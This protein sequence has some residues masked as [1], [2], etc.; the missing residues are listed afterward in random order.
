M[1]GLAA[2]LLIAV[3]AASPSPSAAPSP[4]PAEEHPILRPP[5]TEETPAVGSP[6]AALY[7]F[8]TE[9]RRSEFQSAAKYLDLSAIPPSDREGQGPKL[10]RHLKVVLDRNIWFD[11]SKVSNRAEGKTDDGLPPNAEL[12]GSISSAGALVDVVMVRGP[13]DTGELVWRFSPALVERIPALYTE[14][15][16]G[17]IGDHVPAWMHRMGPLGLEA[18]Q[19]LG[20][21]ILLVG[22][23]F[24]SNLA[25]K[26]FVRTLR[27]LAKRTRAAF[28]DRL[29]ETM[30][31]PFRFT[32]WTIVLAVGV[33]L[34]HISVRASL[35]IDRVLIAFAFVAA[36]RIVSGLSEAWARAACEKLEREGHRSGAGVVNVINRVVKMLLACIA[37]IGLLQAFGFNVTG[38]LAGLGI[39][40]VAIALAAQ[41]T[42][43]NLFGG[44]TVMADKPVRI[45]D[46]C[47]FGD[48]SGWVED[49][50]FRSTRIR[51]L[52]RTI[53]SVPNAEFSS[54]QIENLA[55]RD[56]MRFFTTLGLRYE[57]T[58]DQ[59]RVVLTSIR[60]I[61]IGHP[62][63]GREEMRARFAALGPSSLDIEVNA[64]VLTADATQFQA[65]REDLLLRFMDAVRDA[66]TGFAFPSSTVYLSRDRGPD[67]ARAAAAEG[68][69]RALRAERKLPFP[70]FTAREVDELADQLD[71][72]PEGSSSAIP[73]L[74]NS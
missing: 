57:T 33:S 37:I 22:G 18:W 16:F 49:I 10:A 74:P 19:A 51:T 42:I 11:L 63:V 5:P 9:G 71:Y 41:K 36:V 70:D 3:A 4:A 68:T 35:W 55:E 7:A 54:V 14:F 65:I 64:Y 53:L 72:P 58:P 44:L 1:S 8:L 73:P 50:G 52:E 17:W 62:K 47:R 60:K 66:G 61:L 29:L 34:L 28:D 45:G 48:K 12:L 24:A 67:P 59:M 38:L 31:R 2:S 15:G 6:R 39:G 46:F 32:L 21:L 30:R 43:E 25:T 27:P 20:F 40:G 23:W 69:I 13:A 56:R 26:V